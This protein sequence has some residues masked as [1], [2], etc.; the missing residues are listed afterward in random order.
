[1]KRFG[2]YLLVR[3]ISS[4]GMADVYAA[5]TLG[6]RGF[7]KR[8][9]IKRIYPHL[10]DRERFIRM[11]SDEAKIASHL[12]HPSIV[13]I[14]DF[15]QQD[16]VPYIAMEYVAG[17]DL[18]HLMKRLVE[19]DEQLPV[20]IACHVIIKLCDAL[21][22]AHEWSTIDGTPQQIVHRDVSPRNVLIGY[23]GGL[24][25]TDFGIARAR[26]REEHTEHGLIKG[27]ARYMS[28]E[29]VQG[30]EVDRRSD[31]FSLGAV[32]VE[33]LIMKPLFA[34][35]DK[36]SVLL[37]IREGRIDTG[38]LLG[39]PARLRPV[40]ERALKIDPDERYWTAEE[41]KDELLEALGDES[42][43]ALS[44]ASV[45]N[46]MRRIFAD[47][48]EATDLLDR[49][50]ERFLAE[51]GSNLAAL[52]TLGDTPE[53]QPYD[54]VFPL[55]PIVTVDSSDQL[56]VRANASTPPVEDRIKQL[57][58]LK[59]PLDSGADVKPDI[60]G[61]LA[62]ESL[63]SLFHQLA[64]EREAGQL[65]VH[66]HPLL[67]S[68]FFE[69]GQPVY[70]VSNVEAEMFGEHLV[71]KGIITRDQHRAVIDFAV[72]KPLRL[73]EAFLA[74]GVFQPHEL[75][76]YLA[77][78]VQERILDLF[79]WFSGRFSFYR[80]QTPP[81]AGFDLNLRT[82]TL[83]RTG[84]LERTPMTVIKRSLDR[85]RNQSPVRIRGDLPSDMTLSGREQRMLHL[86]DVEHYTISNLI[87]KEKTEE[88]VLRLLYLLH[89]TGFITFLEA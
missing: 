69:D 4:G 37:A 66:R 83:I 5:R 10:L 79:S 78:Q 15:G 43:A 64:S 35:T 57:E 17:S 89:E 63:P 70:A 13:Q 24:R 48:I 8:V 47:E 9:A 76:E 36:I 25:L 41:F 54:D 49:E 20:A 56:G 81:E 23:D 55:S 72:K 12:I 7:S 38:R 26:D 29:A 46:L 84:V 51:H 11:F 16:G 88:H 34:G 59:L 67:K 14:H 30:I 33:M 42:T 71:A 32:F 61:E 40:I 2:K 87:K 74:L 58:G 80:D 50:V 53:V 1:M 22:Y 65:L 77:D 3:K 85:R 31:L 18:H 21:H 44:D 73:T 19:L 68:I 6:I 52:P 75:F 62:R 60:E 28:P 86:L 39:V 45:A 82:Y 27:K